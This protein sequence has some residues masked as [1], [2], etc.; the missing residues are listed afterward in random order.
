MDSD[1]HP[2][3]SQYHQPQVAGSDEEAE[4][5]VCSNSDPP[6]QP[7][8]TQLGVHESSASLHHQ[9]LTSEMPHSTPLA[10]NDSVSE[11]QGASEFSLALESAPSS[12]S[13]TWDLATT[14]LLGRFLR[15]GIKLS[16]TRHAEFESR[17]RRIIKSRFKPN[18]AF[19]LN[20]PKETF[21]QRRDGTVEERRLLR[22]HL[23]D[24]VPP[25]FPTQINP[26]NFGRFPMTSYVPFDNRVQLAC[27]FPWLWEYEQCRIR[28]KEHIIDD[29]Q[30]LENTHGDGD[31]CIIDDVGGPENESHRHESYR[32]PASAAT[33]YVRVD[34]RLVPNVSGDEVFLAPWQRLIF[35]KGLST[36]AKPDRPLFENGQFVAL[37]YIALDDVK[38]F[39][40]LHYL[41]RGPTSDAITEAVKLHLNCSRR[42][43]G[44]SKNPYMDAS[45]SFHITFYERISGDARFI[46]KESWKIGHMY[47]K[48][49]A[50][51]GTKAPL[52]RRSAFTTLVVTE[53]R[54][55][56]AELARTLK[57]SPRFGT[58]LVLCP[59]KSFV[60]PYDIAQ[61]GEHPVMWDQVLSFAGIQ[62]SELGVIREM[63]SLLTRRW[64]ELKDYLAELLQEDFMEPEIY[65]KLIF[66]DD[67]LSTSKKY[68]WV[69]ACLQEFKVSITDNVN[70]WEL[71]REA[72]LRNHNISPAMDPTQWIADVDR[73]CEVLREVK[74]QMDELAAA[75]QARRDGLFNA[76]AL[77][78]S[79]N[80]TRLGQNVKLL[81]YVSIFYLPLAFCAALWAIPNIDQKGTKT[82]FSIT[83][84]VT[85]L[86]NYL[87]VANLE[88][89][90]FFLKSI[91]NSWRR[92]VV[93][94]MKDDPARY[95][96]AHGQ[97]LEDSLPERRMGPSEWTIWWYQ[98]TKPF[99]R[100]STNVED[101]EELKVHSS[102][103]STAS[104]E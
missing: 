94:Q 75:V 19:R 36:V 97:R 80:S 59:S 4:M 100:Y 69:L 70:Q 86:V 41:A 34:S 9:N 64:L 78:E 51:P 18:S 26:G 1:L 72:R 93:Q 49:D 38:L 87:L 46:E 73:F 84:L 74:A 47:T 50:P 21:R 23:L 2:G 98:I 48:P 55:A 7:E 88:N 3:E 43:I 52:F 5:S 79:M 8:T 13:D 61:K 76:S 30:T 82:A 17:E 67:K 54:Y 20:F 83:A 99:R 16:L 22:G 15:P 104:L 29:P 35:C 32:A 58:M 81:T 12:E 91:Y 31:F 6:D 66:D 101:S 56:D 62:V 65:V 85:G 60:G 96:K 33:D 42:V 53:D 95:W 39:E 40:G 68:F 28:W 44:E 103:S 24:Y 89:I 14:T 25:G 11:D 90:V 57:K 63:Y 77:G 10:V 92:N 71:Y 37:P 27:D 45:R 102:S